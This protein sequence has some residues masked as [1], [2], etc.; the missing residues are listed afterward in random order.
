MRAGVLQCTICVFSELSSLCLECCCLLVPSGLEMLLIPPPLHSP[1]LLG[2]MAPALHVHPD[3]QAGTQRH[4][5]GSGS[6]VYADSSSLPTTHIPGLPAD[7]ASALCFISLV[8]P[9]SSLWI[10]CQ[11]HPVVWKV[12]PGRSQGECDFPVMSVS[13]RGT[14]SIS[15]LI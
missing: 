3:A 4:S 7:P 6:S 13:Q 14:A 2:L 10:P 9:L 15:C 1:I 12:S 8:R 5:T 11:V